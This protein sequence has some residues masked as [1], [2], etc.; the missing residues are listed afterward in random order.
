MKQ[1]PLFILIMLVLLLLWFHPLATYFVGK[2]TII[3]VSLGTGF[4]FGTY[5]AKVKSAPSWT[6]KE[7]L[8]FLLRWLGVR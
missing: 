4:Y 5:F 8:K 6:P 1:T 7:H 2:L 3:A